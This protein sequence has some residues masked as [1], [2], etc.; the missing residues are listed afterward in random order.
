[1]MGGG[2]GKV[3]EAEGEDDWA[4]EPS[5]GV[6]RAELYGEASMVVMSLLL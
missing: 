6:S 5:S 3:W 2:V 1:M 4:W